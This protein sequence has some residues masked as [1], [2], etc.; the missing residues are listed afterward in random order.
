MNKFLM[1]SYC[2]VDYSGRLS[3]A[4]GAPS[5]RRSLM[6][7]DADKLSS[8]RLFLKLKRD[9]GEEVAAPP[10]RIKERHFR[11][12][13]VSLGDT[14]ETKEMFSSSPVSSVESDLYDPQID[15][16]DK[17]SSRL[18]LSLK[19]NVKGYE[20]GSSED[21]D[22]DRLKIDLKDNNGG[23]SHTDDSESKFYSS[24]RDLSSIGGAGRSL[25]SAGAVNNSAS[26]GHGG[27]QS[28]GRSLF[29]SA[30]AGLHS[31]N[32]RSAGLQTSESK[33]ASSL[34]GLHSDKKGT[35][36]YAQFDRLSTLE[37]E[38]SHTRTEDPPPKFHL[39]MMETRPFSPVFSDNDKSDSDSK[40]P[41][42]P[43]ISSCVSSLASPRGRRASN[44][45]QTLHIPFDITGEVNNH[46]KAK[47]S[48]DLDQRG[49]SSS[50]QKDHFDQVTASR[51]DWPMSDQV[52]STKSVSDWPMSDQV[53]STKS[54][55][56]WTS[57]SVTTVVSS[58]SPSDASVSVTLSVNNSI[59]TLNSH[60][61]PAHTVS[62]SVAA[63]QVTDIFSADR[64]IRLYNRNTSTTTTNLKTPLN[65]I[66][67]SGAN[68]NRRPEVNTSS[69][70]GDNN[71][72]SSLAQ[73]QN[74]NISDK[75]MSSSV[76][77]VS[78]SLKWDLRSSNSPKPMDE[79]SNH[80]SSKMESKQ[81]SP[82]Q[83]KEASHWSSQDKDAS[84]WPNQ[85]KDI[86]HWS[87]QSDKEAR[88]GQS[89]PK[90]PP[91]K[92]I[93]NP[94]VTTSVH[95]PTHVQDSVKTHCAPKQPL[96]Y[97]IN[98]TQEQ[99]EF[100]S[101][102]NSQAP[103]GTTLM[104]ETG[105]VVGGTSSPNSSRPSSQGS[106]A[107]QLRIREDNISVDDKNNVTDSENVKCSD[108][109]NREGKGK[110]SL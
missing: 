30:I 57:K 68:N 9:Q 48:T 52:T 2:F 4:D 38:S 70:K 73:S 92:I 20:G 31:D 101:S 44:E 22:S 65:S 99:R 17:L 88:D 33:F 43:T 11:S 36:E 71:V 28:P 66:S 59:S 108:G 81:D 46:N 91:L 75:T 41:M 84:H 72:V 82:S 47:H 104:M 106:A 16:V 78:S 54:G 97:V 23:G 24:N 18:K 13:S 5:S 109:E 26:A 3:G 63:S 42:F 103:G 93:I 83:D 60:T 85:D 29:S 77:S 95:A 25:F 55:S 53:T 12:Y 56:D 74:V 10:K 67:S 94:K 102:S 107:A 6:P 90:V 76:S 61:M 32:R 110:I 96:P 37:P 35:V 8:P 7:K 79:G 105:G 69:T 62:T 86:S 49:S 19:D 64:N 40:D 80:S 50:V 87:P 89:T 45:D 21:N 15:V 58:E 100:C 39:K 1:L 98:P 34:A 14:E 27:T 51:H